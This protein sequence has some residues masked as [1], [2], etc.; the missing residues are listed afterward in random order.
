[1]KYKRIPLGFMTSF[2]ALAIG[3]SIANY[4]GQIFSQLAEPVT[5]GLTLDSSNRITT[6]YS[7]TERSISTDSGK[8]TVKFNYT[9]VSPLTGGHCTIENSGILVNS[10]H[11]LSIEELSINFSTTGTLRFRTS[12]DASTWGAYNDAVSEQTYTLSSHPYYV[13]FSALNAKVDLYSVSYG[14]T[15]TVNEEADGNYE[16]ALI[17]VIDFWNPANVADVVTTTETNVT[18]VNGLSYSDLA[19]TNEIDVASTITSSKAYQKRYGG[20]G[21]GSSENNGTLT[22]NLL[23]AFQVDKISVI[24]LAYD[25][26]TSN[27]S[28]AGSSASATSK[29]FT[30]KRS[31]S[32]A[33]I[34]SA[35]TLEWA[36]EAKQ[37]SLIFSTVSKRRLAIY[38]IM[39]YSQGK[40]IPAPVDEVGFTATDSNA[41]SYQERSI[42]DND[43]GLIVS[44]HFSDGTTSSL[45]KGTGSNNFTY[46][47][48]NSKNEV[49]SSSSS[50]GSAGNYT[51]SVSYKSYIPVRISLIVGE[52]TIFISSIEAILAEDQFT[53][54]D[55]LLL[56][57]N[58]LVDLTFSDSSTASNLA[59]ADLSS[60]G[61][62]LALITPGQI[63]YD[64]TNVFGTAG[65]WTLKVYDSTNSSI[66]CNIAVTVV[67]VNVSGVSID[68]GSLSLE[69]GQSATLV[70]NITPNDAINK[71]LT[72]ASTAPSVASVSTSGLVTAK[73]IGTAKIT[74]TT[75]SGGFT[76]TCTVNVTAAPVM[77]KTAMAYDYT[78]YTN[79]NM[80]AFD[81]TPSSG[82]PKL[83]VI[84]VWFTDSSTYI[85]SE[86]KKANVLSDIT[87]VYFGTASSTGWH[88]VSSFYNEESKGRVNLTGTVSEWYNAGQ[89]TAYY[90]DASQGQTRTTTLVTTASD[91]YFT[92]NPIDSRQNYDTD[93]DGYLDGVLLIPGA[94][95]YSAARS[96]YENLWAYCYW[97]QGT[98]STSSPKA[99]AFFW[100]SYDFMYGRST[101]TS[102]AGTSYNGGDTSHCNV[103][104]HTFTHEMGHVFGLDDYYDYSGSYSPGGGFS[105]QDYNVGG[106]DPYSVMALGWA[107]P[108]IPTTSGSITIGAF[109][110]THDL[111]LLTPSWNAY[112]SP[113]DEYLL[114]ELYT[115]TGL[116]QM[117][118]TYTYNDNY[119]LGPSTT[120]IRLWHV[121][122][123]LTT[124]S[125]YSYSKSLHSNVSLNNI[126][127]AMS[128]TYYK[129]GDSSTSYISPLGQSYANYNLLQLIRNNTAETFKPTADFSAGNLFT[130]GQSFSMSTYGSQF[131]N[132]GKLNSNTNL[133]WSFS[134]VITG[135]G[136]S[137][138]ATITLTRS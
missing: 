28:I 73:S 6:S 59:Y 8:W 19:H 27:L 77:Q 136:A 123:R 66:Y 101:A 117:D 39:L 63:N 1:M 76:D 67:A 137:A 46:T 122:A 93:G 18:Y 118:S 88:S 44:A 56:T 74:V 50:F 124:Y 71:A 129:A 132:N 103:D 114:L 48:K 112:N 95:D 5:Y 131:V 121:D 105:M 9:N 14:Y 20:I 127:H 3:V 60:Y 35:Q 47:I 61:L 97:L 10:D 107:D 102:R 91:W 31:G 37:S 70:A 54:S 32:A 138:T 89:N 133:G 53:T 7:S 98:A 128:N 115:P 130:N 99:N 120:G 30:A 23:S 62:S 79:N 34:D 45:T 81:S 36:F 78:D 49:V 13:E 111:I 100:A 58:L 38:R 51:L 22:I 92:N 43:N 104:S 85:T 16:G 15:C 17:G 25:T 64:I 11:I 82:D 134:V 125:G 26:G 94:P 29:G 21:L 110:T 57:D 69:V 68:Q 41:S 12:Y 135:S 126:Y 4:S 80:Y 72:W 116:N 84:P 52:N 109:Q 86:T 55:T 108:Y 65:N 90:G 24:G 113:F 75:T 87:D 106:H 119:P 2:T 40:T 33:D 96:S 83:L 42:F